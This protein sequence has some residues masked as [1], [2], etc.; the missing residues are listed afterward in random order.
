MRCRET[1]RSSP[2]H[3]R[4][5][6]ASRPI[7]LAAVEECC[8]ATPTAVE[9]CCIA[10]PAVHRRCLSAASQVLHHNND[11]SPATG[12]GR[13]W[14]TALVRRL[15]Q[16]TLSEHAALSRVAL[17]QPVGE[18]APLLGASTDAAVSRRSTGNRRPVL[19]RST[20]GSAI[21]SAA[22]RGCYNTSPICCIVTRVRAFASLN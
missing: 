18:D 19:H 8:N 17:Q 4:G 11:S 21:C 9:K 13:V 7:R 14:S 22:T 1:S 3:H 10:V 20:G 5:P 2:L 15:Q 6:S 12:H 16:R